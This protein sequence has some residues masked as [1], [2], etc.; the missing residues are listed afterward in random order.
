MNRILTHIALCPFDEI[1]QLDKV[2]VHMSD[3]NISRRVLGNS[4]AGSAIVNPHKYV[5]RGESAAL[6][7][8]MCLYIAQILSGA[9]ANIQSHIFLL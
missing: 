6:V 7:P 8:L 9:C 2:F 1:F 3:P 5:I 4:K